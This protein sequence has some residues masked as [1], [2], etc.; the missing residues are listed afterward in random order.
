MKGGF[1][2]SLAVQSGSLIGL[3]IYALAALAGAGLLLGSLTL[4]LAA[5]AAGTILLFSLGVS[6]IRSGYKLPGLHL[7]AQ[8]SGEAAGRQAFLSGAALSLANPLDLV[9]W[10]SISSRIL[11]DPAMG[12]PLFWA[13]F[14]AGC[15][16]TS[17]GLA[18]FAGLWRERFSSR[19]VRVISW[20]CGLALI[21]FGLR[22]GL[23]TGQQFAAW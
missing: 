17:L 14:F 16:V 19:A 21:S 20:A 12:G 13:G 3:A 15:L 11:A 10:L 7:P 8:P 1:I 5:G 2:T 4:Q 18:L 6:T 23:S 22:L 9:F